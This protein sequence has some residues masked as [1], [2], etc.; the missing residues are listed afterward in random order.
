MFPNA[1]FRSLPNHL[2]WETISVAA[3]ESAE[4]VIA[5]PLVTVECHWDS[6]R[7]VPCRTLLTNGKLSC[8]CQ[9]EPRSLRILGYCP[10]ISKYRDRF[11]VLLSATVAQRVESIKPGTGVRFTRP[12]KGKRPLSVTLVPDYEMGEDFCKRVRQAA[13]HDIHEYLIHLWQDRE[14]CDLFG[15]EHVPSCG[16]R[17]GGSEVTN[18]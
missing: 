5:G 4:G 12:K 3:G 10:I 15:I 2:K 6:G 13:V 7:S 18:V 9:K 17:Q 16:Q 1:T 14:L 8:V 11:V